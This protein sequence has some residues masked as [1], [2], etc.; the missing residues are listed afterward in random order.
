M[1]E[2]E[3]LQIAWDSIPGR[4]SPDVAK[5]VK[6]EKD[7]VTIAFKD[8]DVW[9]QYRPSPSAIRPSKAEVAFSKVLGRP[10]RVHPIPS[11]IPFETEAERTARLEQEAKRKAER[12]EQE[13][14]WKEKEI[15]DKIHRLET[16]SRIPE[17]ALTTRTLDKFERTHFNE[18]AYKAA[19]DLIYV[20][21]DLSPYTHDDWNNMMEVDGTWPAWALTLIG[22]TGCGKTHLAIGAGIKYLKAQNGVL[23]WQVGDLFEEL[24]AQLFRDSKSE[25]YTILS[26]LK[27]VD[28]LILDDFGVQRDSDF[29]QEIL[30]TTLNCRYE[31]N[32]Q[33]II[34]SNLR[35]IQWPTESYARIMSRLSEGRVIEFDRNAPDY[36]IKKGKFRQGVV[37]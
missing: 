11:I 6:L 27:T 10:I 21:Y 25:Y 3:Q 23:Y 32:L 2:L 29:T 15:R 35:F 14:Q 28:L 5:V 36:R 4:P 7:V 1:T 24:K 18:T 13:R 34:T 30:D 19:C 9:E 8:A 16:E 12:E 20:H 37:K 31:N 26:K 33:T 17:N 22:P